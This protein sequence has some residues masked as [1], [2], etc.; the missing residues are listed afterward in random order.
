MVGFRVVKV[1]CELWV[2]V[3]VGQPKVYIGRISSTKS[4]HLSD[5]QKKVGCEFASNCF[6]DVM[7]IVP[8]IRPMPVL[9]NTT[10]LI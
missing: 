8:H 5:E 6:F 4:D 3:H 10:Q 9:N 1:V 7:L 2:V